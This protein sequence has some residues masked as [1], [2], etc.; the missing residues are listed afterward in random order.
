MSAHNLIIGTPYVDLGGKSIVRNITRTGEYCELEYHK[1][2]WS[3]SNSFRVDGEIY[4]VKKEVVL[5]ID[6]RWNDK[7][8]FI[9]PRNNAKEVIWTKEPYPENWEYMYGMTRLG[10][11]LNYFPNYL[12]NVVAPTDTRRRPDQRALE[13]GDM[14]LANSEK[15]RLEEKQRAIRRYKEK[16][17]IEHKPA[18]FEEKFN[19]DDN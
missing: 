13:N 5:K 16:F 19:P 4:N 9:N 10:I 1:R 12:H 6:G 17:G 8:Y 2:G 11:Q 3:S 15:N 18:Y 14:K 7:I